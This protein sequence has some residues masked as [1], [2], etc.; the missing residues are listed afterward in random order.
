M[1]L[2]TADRKI[3]R[4]FD[5][6][7]QQF[8]IKAT[9]K[10]FDIL[11]SGL[12]SNKPLAI[13]RE[14]SCNAYD[15][16]I[17]AGK[18]NVPIKVKLP[19]R[20]SPTLE[21]RD[22]GTGLSHENV[23][24]LY[25]TYF[26]STKQDS[27]DFIGA[28]GLGSKSPF[29]YT[30]AFTVESCFKGVKRLY[31]AFLN[32]ER[33]PA[34]VLL[35]EQATD[36][37]SGMS[38]SLNV[39]DGDH[40]MF[41]QAAQSVFRYFDPYPEIYGAQIT[42]TSVKY[43]LEGKNWKVRDDTTYNSTPYVVQGVVA[44]P[45]NRDQLEK[46]LSPAARALLRSPVDL[47]VPIGDVE[48]A[49]SREALQ[50][51]KRTIN[52]LSN[53]MENAAN[54]LGSVITK[55]VSEQKTAWD[56]RRKVINLRRGNFKDI[57]DSMIDNGKILWNGKPLSANVECDFTNIK[58]TTLFIIDVIRGNKLPSRRDFDIGPGVKK[59]IPRLAIGSQAFRNPIMHNF[60]IIDD[61]V[62]GSGS[63][64]ANALQGNIGG[65]V[66]R[67]TSVKSYNQKEIDYIV[68]LLG[69]PP[70]ILASS[71]SDPTDKKIVKYKPKSKNTVWVWK[72]FSTNGGYR[73]NKENRT[74]SR[75]CWE[76]KNIDFRAAGIYI[77]V[78]KFTIIGRNGEMN[79]GF[80]HMLKAAHVLGIVK[81]FDNMYA[82]TDKQI[83]EAKKAN[84]KWINVYDYVEEAFNK[85]NKNGEMY[86]AY[87]FGSSHRTVYGDEINRWT[88][89]VNTF[90]NEKLDQTNVF[91]KYI[92]RCRFI[93]NARYIEKDPQ[94][95]ERVLDIVRSLCR[96]EEFDKK[97]EELILQQIETW[98]NVLSK[99]PLFHV[100]DWEKVRDNISIV[101]SYLK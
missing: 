60:V 64:I 36:E 26:D 49:A 5:A 70:T 32:E 87:T 11:S 33:I 37:P 48:V 23:L 50:Y 24:T 41:Q 72:G 51:T 59:S 46:H 25:T 52:N 27:N 57:V 95:A 58:D 98:D 89:M 97:S 18:D 12:Y 9:S 19:N 93:V 84:K 30:D 74:Y 40:Y 42:Q 90:Y 96:Q 35:S 54:E 4:G 73:R 78:K 81:N 62:R 14:L 77:P 88:E 92:E 91:G 82:L 71:L 3:Q 69:N 65:C 99:Y 80:D 76:T 75:L 15:A 31:S 79:M 47:Y 20:L 29:S 13:I 53:H 56:A 43:V 22:E 38:I 10:A 7:E 85:L 34:I 67:P 86:I 2:Q 39:K 68:N 16:H 61:I 100:I 94:T 6:T 45:L 55:E 44:Y 101:K 66:I 1:K 63:V 83:K 8:T 28:L 17:A 21:I